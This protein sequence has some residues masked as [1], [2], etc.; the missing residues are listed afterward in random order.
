MTHT[1]PTTEQLSPNGDRPASENKPSI[2]PFDT[3]RFRVDPLADMEVEK[4]LTTVPVR[5]PKRTEFFR[6]HCGR[7]FTVDMYLL[8]RE[9][10][11][12]REAYLVD[13]QV[14]HLVLSEL[15]RVQLST[16]INKHGDI[17]LWPVRLPAD[18]RDRLRRMS[19]SALEGAG[20]GRDPMGQ[21][22]LGTNIWA[23]GKCTGLKAIWAHRSGRTS[24]SVTSGARVPE[25]PDRHPGAR[26]DP[27]TRGSLLDED[28]GP[29]LGP[30]ESGELQV[31]QVGENE[32]P[33]PAGRPL[34]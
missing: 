24:R 21:A 23:R 11:M 2:D 4:V 16:A 19:D 13:P 33:L 29:D 17:F 9:D 1:R 31:L 10:G 34:P 26:G 8:E 7:D 28:P 6:V 32:T 14:Q 15:R 3:A 18:D 12:D 22:G 30:S 27:G 20:A 5:K 25:L